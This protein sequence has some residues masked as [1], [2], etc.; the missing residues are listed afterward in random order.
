MSVLAVGTFAQLLFS[1]GDTVISS[2]GLDLYV[3]FAGSRNFGFSELVQGNLPLWNPHQ[4]SGVPYFGEIQTALLYPL[5]AVF[6]MLP[7]A[8][9]INWSVTLHL[10]LAGVFMYAWASHRGLRP[11]AAFFCGVLF[12]Y[13]GGYFPRLFAGHLSDQATITW[14]PMVMLVI[15]GTLAR[16]SFGW[17]LAGIAVLSMFLLSG[18]IQYVYFTAIATGPYVLFRLVSCEQRGRAI[19]GLAAMGIGALMVTAIQLW[20]SIQMDSESARGAGVGYDFASSMTYPP[21]NVIAYFVPGFFG[22]AFAFPYWGRNL[23]WEA[24]PFIGLVGVVFALYGA[25]RGPKEQRQLSTTLVIGLLVLSVGNHTPLYDLLYAWLPMF[26]K[27]RGVSKF[28]VVATPFLILLAG[29]GLDELRRSQPRN[30][31]L[32]YVFG[33]L[34]VVLAVAAL[35]L[36]FSGDQEGG[37]WHAFMGKIAA[38]GE[39]YKQWEPEFVPEAARFAS[40][41]LWIA[42]GVAFL[43]SIFVAVALR[44]PKAIYVLVLIGIAE[45]VVAHRNTLYT[46]DL[47]NIRSQPVETIAQKFPGDHRVWH[48]GQTQHAMFGGYEVAGP[49]IPLQRYAEFFAYSQGLDPDDA[50]EI[51]EY[52]YNHPMLR[53]LRLRFVIHGDPPQV[54]FDPNTPVLPRIALMPQYKVYPERDDLLYEFDDPEFD[55]DRVVLLEEEPEIKPTERGAKGTAYIEDE[56]TDHMTIVANVPD[57]TIILITDNHA[58]GWRATAL[59]DSAQDSYQLLPGNY[60]LRA[61][62]VGPGRHHIRLEYLP[63]VFVIGK[64]VSIASLLVYG[65]LLAWWWRGRRRLR[66]RGELDAVAGSVGEA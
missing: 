31:H 13:A 23:W 14:I 55:F 49:H 28:M 52:A 44:F 65:L 4:F 54:D 38:S 62:P 63:S 12:M 46:F 6:L 60:T 20:S 58:E 66:D 1:T 8:H 24:T 2:I 10:W 5:N 17:V 22:G 34:C 40:N 53:L 64:W 7:L 21:E 47:I 29:I 19:V 3:E 18:H 51:L 48:V 11:F 56:S 39:S 50:S 15:D 37:F 45:V 42:A 61:I 57:A 35:A 41:A 26:D 32:A 16:R 36:G 59:P 25:W 33:G 27:F 43:S 9:A 30:K